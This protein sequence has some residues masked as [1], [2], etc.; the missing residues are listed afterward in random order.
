MILQQA[1]H[2]SSIYAFVCAFA[3]A[4]AAFEIGSARILDSVTERSTP[5]FKHLVGVIAILGSFSSSPPTFEEL[6]EKY[7]TKHVGQ[8]A[9]A[10][11]A[12][13]RGPRYVLLTAY[14]IEILQS[15]CLVTLLQ[16]VHDLVWSHERVDK[17]QSI[18]RTSSLSLWPP[19]WTEKMR[20]VESL[21]KLM[22]YWNICAICPDLRTEKVLI[23]IHM[24]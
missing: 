16:N 8:P 18:A 5:E 6:V 20:V 7:K 2:L 19:S 22:I 24:S 21:W 15:V 10:Y 14:R 11:A 1:P 23:L 3:R 4:N 17:N 12:G 13:T 9:K